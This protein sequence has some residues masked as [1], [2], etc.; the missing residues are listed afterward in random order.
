MRILITLLF[1]FTLLGTGIALAQFD[2]E[3][4]GSQVDVS[5]TEPTTNAD[6]SPL[7]D[8]DH[9]TTYYDNGDGPVNAHEEPATALT[10]GGNIAVQ[11]IVPVADG[12]EANVDFWA[13]A[14]DQS[15]NESEKSPIDTERIDRLPPA[16]IQ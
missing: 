16:G 15:G 1:V 14:T 10:G 2:A 3:V 13:T 8:L 6:G 7:T 9:T 5:Y 11:I 4:S 12:E